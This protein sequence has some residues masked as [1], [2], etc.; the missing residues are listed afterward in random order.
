MLSANKFRIVPHKFRIASGLWQHQTTVPHIC[1]TSFVYAEPLLHRPSVYAELMRNY[2]ELCGIMQCAELWRVCGWGVVRDEVE[3]VWAKVLGRF[4]FPPEK[5]PG[6]VG[7]G[8]STGK[9]SG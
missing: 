9:L 2:A 7:E 8:S 4:S 5:W 3:R 1:G 6:E